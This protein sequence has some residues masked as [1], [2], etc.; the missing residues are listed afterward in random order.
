MAEAVVLNPKAIRG[1]VERICRSGAFRQSARLTSFLRYTVDETLA[2]RAGSLKEY[3][4]GVE[5]YGRP[6]DYDPKADSIV[7]SEAVRLR[8][9]L[10]RYYSNEGSADRVR[11]DYPKGAYAP[12]FAYQPEQPAETVIPAIAVLPFANVSGDSEDE[13][14][15]DGLTDELI[16]A[17]ARIPGLR[18]IARTSVFQFK[19]KAVDVRHA[20]QALSAGTILEGSVRRWQNRVRICAQLIDVASGS[21]LWSETWDASGATSSRYRMR[22]AGRWPG[23]SRTNSPSA[24]PFSSRPIRKRIACI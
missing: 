9:R 8:A 16:A 6:G 4:I 12:S 23:V 5:V 22:S 10:Q 18:V 17:L 1:Q 7:R 21:H 20:G 11:I 2:G 19:N 15:S 13:F 24:P 3:I 14:F